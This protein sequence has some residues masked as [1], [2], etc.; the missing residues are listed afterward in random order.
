[1]RVKLL[2]LAGLIAIS[3]T[4]FAQGL[5]QGTV[6]D[7]STGES[8]V[9]VN[10]YLEGTT[11]GN[12]TDI[13]GKFIIKDV[14]PGTYNVIA[15]FISYSSDTIKGVKILN[16]KTVTLEFSLSE[17]TMNLQGVTIQ[18][19]K[20]TDTEISVISAMKQ[21]NQIVV[22]VSSQQISK[23]QDKDAS[24]VIRRLPGVTITDGR[25]IIV[26]G[27][28]ERYNSVWLN[29]CPAPS[30]EADKKAFS[31]DIIPSNLI[32]NILIY[33][34]S[35]PE[36]PADFA[37][38]HIQI[39]TKNLPD[40][41]M[42]SAGYSLGFNE[43]ATFKNFKYQENG[44]TEWLGFDN[45]THR[46]PG[47]IPDIYQ[48]K[49]LQDY[50]AEGLDPEESLRRKNKI[51]EISRS[52]NDNNK[53]LERTALPDQKFNIDLLRIFYPGKVKIG[54]TTAI[55]YRTG[56]DI[57][58]IYRSGVE[59][60]FIDGVLYSEHLNDTRWSKTY[61]IGALHNWSMTFGKN[62]I[63]F[64]NLF[65]QLGTSRITERFGTNHYRGDQKLYKTDL[66]Y[67]SRSIYAGNLGGEHKLGN[68]HQINWVLGYSMGELNRPDHTLI[69]YFAP[70][71]DIEAGTYYPY[72]LD[73][74]ST[75]NTNSNS[76]LFTRIN[77][78]IRNFGINYKVFVKIGSFIPEIK[79]GFF[80]EQKQRNF[81]IRP[82]GIVWSRPV[83][84]TK[85]LY[86][87]IDSIYLDENFNFE[88]N[89]VIYREEFKDTYKYKVENSVEAYYLSLR[90]PVSRHFAIYGGFRA[91][92]YL[93]KLTSDYKP[94][95]VNQVD[96]LNI[97]PTLGIT[98]NL[99]EKNLIRLA[100]G[101]TTNRPEFRERTDFAFYD[102]EENVIVYGNAGLKSAYIDNY[103]LRYEWYP[104]PGELVTIGGFYKKFDDPIEASWIPVS[105]G[106]WDL[107]YLNALE[108]TSLGIEVDVRKNLYNFKN[109]PGFLSYLSNFTIVANA[110]FIRSRVKN[111]SA[112]VFLRDI[113]RAM[114]GQ[115]PFIVNAGVYY[116]SENNGISFSLLYNII[117]PRI[118]GIG[119]PDTPNTYEMPRHNVDFTIIKKFGDH[120]QIKAGIKE[121]LNQKMVYNQTFTL[122]G[123]MDEIVDIKSFRPGRSYSVGLSYKF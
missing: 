99:N 12:S 5:I 15:S 20:K 74:M 32:N 50:N 29:G 60:Y 94:G 79:A 22:G 46:L 84:D 87:P 86:L 61:Q 55:N 78:D 95:Y 64:R 18:E 116:N 43:G 21:S 11:I 42:I 89:G 102:F 24:E 110:S 111:D 25:F 28:V 101:K 104:N 75:V 65:N 36:I 121:L 115:S 62:M 38:A 49:V 37:G 88:N 98:F 91:E 100:Y 107:R 26:R 45:G 2:F 114:F 53:I 6:H 8:M 109:N 4:I 80:A 93:L 35:A 117:G 90:L 68:N 54:N 47:I 41:N 72:Q 103:D 71:K 58:N 112:Y 34:T 31:F 106:G 97:F 16:G 56:S 59:N 69:S 57:E 52:F 30:T 48:M 39:F 9:G 83:F 27:L 14:N 10:V 7:Q 120:L 118:Q 96:T 13:S 92:N 123:A 70:V 119:T 1:M 108:A 77:E 23:S 73:Y 63:E 19:R 44:S 82:F 76:K 3:Q 122:D 67:Q 17:A 81:E 33:K 113:N 66:M 105:S 51:L 40:E 85:L